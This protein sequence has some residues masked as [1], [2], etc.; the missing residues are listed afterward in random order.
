MEQISATVP[1]QSAEISNAMIQL[2]QSL[3]FA[4]LLDEEH[5]RWCHR[6]EGSACI[7]AVQLAEHAPEIK[8][9]RARRSLERCSP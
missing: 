5:N 2:Q 7:S 4:T 1:C 6:T 9:S 8:S 3:M